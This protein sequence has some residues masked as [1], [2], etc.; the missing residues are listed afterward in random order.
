MNRILPGLLLV[1][2]TLTVFSTAA[3]ATQIPIG[4][5]TFD[6]PTETSGAE[7]DITNLTGTNSM[8]GFPVTTGLTFNITSLTVNFVSGPPAVL[9]SAD[10][11]SDMNG[12]F[13]GNNI[14]SSSIL[15]A[16]LVGT[17]SPTAGV[18]VSGVGTETI[19]AA[20]EDGSGNPSV[21]L[22]DSEEEHLAN[23]DLA[24]I[25]AG[26]AS[27]GGPPTAPVPEP[28]TGVLLGTPLAGLIAFRFLTGRRKIHLNFA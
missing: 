16:V 28:G 1:L 12:G 4:L 26:P 13:L 8:T 27:P 10:F 23:G 5:L 20:F 9:T 14:F 6:Q 2:V 7:F 18:A 24:V 22:S 11:T 19:S 21:T 25:Y 17:L 15:S 3:S